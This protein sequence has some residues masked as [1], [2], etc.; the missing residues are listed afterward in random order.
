[1]DLAGYRIYYGETYGPYT[2]VIN[3]DGFTFCDIEGLQLR[4]TYFFAVTGYDTFGNETEFSDESTV[5]IQ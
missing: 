5:I 4:G 3:V 1:M 2:H